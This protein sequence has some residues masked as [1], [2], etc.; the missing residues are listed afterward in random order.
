[1]G[2]LSSLFGKADKSQ[3]AEV[4]KAGAYLV[5][6]RSASEFAGGSAKGA[7]NI[8]LDTLSSNLSKFKNKKNIVVFCQSGI[9]SAQAKNILNKNG[10]ENVFNGVSWRNVSSLMN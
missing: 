8:P 9:R 7:V 5:D 4:I 1:M 3:L 6:V 10:I 2:F